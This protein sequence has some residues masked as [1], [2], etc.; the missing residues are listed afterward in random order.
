MSEV[1]NIRVESHFELYFV[2]SK[3]TKKSNKTTTKAM[4][5]KKKLF[6]ATDGTEFTDRGLYR[7]HEMET[8]YTFRDK[9]STTLTKKP[10][11]VQGQPFVIDNCHDCTLL[12]L[13]HCAQAQIDDVSN[14]KI[15]IGASSGSVF[16]RN[17]NNSTFTIACGQL[18]TRDCHNCTF[19]L[20]CKTEPVIETSS[21]MKFG[22]FNGAYPGHEGD[23][24]DAGLDP[25]INK[26]HAVFD[27]NDSSPSRE[28]WR[29][30][31]LEEQS[32][33]QL[34]CPLG[35]AELCIPSTSK[36]V[37]DL[38]PTT[39]VENYAIDDDYSFADQ[40]EKLSEDEKEH[41]G[42]TLDKIKVLGH[43]AWTIISQT[44]CSVQEFCLGLIFSGMQPL[45]KMLSSG[46]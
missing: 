45:N 33:E 7:K 32:K 35:K 41:A 22:P 28:N 9:Q 40:Y 14:S 6:V 8:Q 29:Y 30:L 39:T 4:K 19:N 18:R 5:K 11:S 2:I 21:G 25:S 34:W 44:V 31:S 27:F 38:R 23:L 37:D 42:T 17:C 1:K 3:A 12:V 24:L 15:F 10:G 46:K 20:Y 13:D 16:V 26:W 36:F 43:R